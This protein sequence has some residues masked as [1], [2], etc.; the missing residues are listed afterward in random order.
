MENICWKIKSSG[1]KT[2]QRT[3]DTW[4]VQAHGTINA[5]IDRLVRALVIVYKTSVSETTV[6]T[7]LVQISVHQW[8]CHAFLSYYKWPIF[9]SIVSTVVVVARL[10]QRQK[11]YLVPD[12]HWHDKRQQ[13]QTAT[14][15]LPALVPV[16]LQSWIF[17]HWFECVF[18][19]MYLILCS[20]CFFFSPFF[21]FFF[22]IHYMYQI[23]QGDS[24]NGFSSN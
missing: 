3:T 14:T 2:V 20:W 22:H 7:I 21:F 24:T 17:G 13:R 10:S 11:Y 1:T 23:H 16:L 5:H 12:W 18:Y 9:I 19:R 4:S 8:P 15:C 6:R